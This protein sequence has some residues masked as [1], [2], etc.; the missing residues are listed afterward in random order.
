MGAFIDASNK[1][2]MNMSFRS[3]DGSEGDKEGEG[4]SGA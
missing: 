4:S 2:G 3:E 1:E